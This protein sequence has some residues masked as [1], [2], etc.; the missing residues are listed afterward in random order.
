[1]LIPHGANLQDFSP[2]CGLPFPCA[3][4]VLWF[5]EVLTLLKPS[6]AACSVACALV[7]YLKTLPNPLVHWRFHHGKCNG[8]LSVSTGVPSWHSDPGCCGPGLPTA[9]FVISWRLPRL[10][11]DMLFLKQLEAPVL[12]SGVSCRWDAIVT[13]HL[14]LVSGKCCNTSLICPPAR[15]STTSQFLTGDNLASLQSLFSF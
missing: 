8:N 6:W 12:W 10:V 5:T 3:D 4:H 13:W 15:K 7:S 14:F 9:P 2:P 1:M 11:H